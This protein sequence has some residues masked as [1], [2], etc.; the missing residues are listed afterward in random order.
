MRNDPVST[1]ES[2]SYRNAG[3]PKRDSIATTSA[4]RIVWKYVFGGI[5][6]LLGMILYCSPDAT[7]GTAGPIRSL[8]GHTHLVETVAFS[9]D[10]KTLASGSWDYTVRLWDLSVANGKQ[11]GRPVILPHE[12]TRLAMAFSPDNSTLVS[13]GDRS[14][15]IWTGGPEYERRLECKGETYHCL[16]FSPDG[17]T[18]ALGAEDGSV[19]LWEMPS[20][21]EQ[22]AL[23]D[24]SGTIRSVAFSPDGRHLVSAS[25]KGRVVL[26]DVSSGLALSTLVEEG[27]QPVGAVAFSPDGRLIAVGHFVFEDR[28]V[29]LFDANT[30][31][32]KNRLVGHRRGIHGLAFSPDGRYLASAGL[33]HCIKLWD[34]DKSSE[35]ANLSDEV[36]WVKSIAFSPEGTRIA[37]CGN[38][39]RVRFWDLKDERGMFGGPDATKSVQ[40]AGDVTNTPHRRVAGTH[41]FRRY[42]REGRGS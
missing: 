31:D 38:D 16:S 3:V 40:T 21:R 34:L 24:H 19:R 37:F 14:L 41:V 12:T 10:G 4:S 35:L 32:L 2:W 29:L 22:G 30:G 9:P 5:V 26:W 27:P 23:Q 18:L 39:E 28:D 33:D 15:T 8:E 36:G 11:T 6:L 13:A 25:Q 20:A 7:E 42:S 17:R 1:N